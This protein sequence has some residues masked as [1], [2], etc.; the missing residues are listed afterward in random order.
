MDL[1][2]VRHGQSVGNRDRMVQSADTPL[3]PAGFEQAA[4]TGRWLA[5]YFARRGT[6]PAALYSS[7][8]LRAW[9]TAEI[10]GQDLRL[11]PIAEPRLRE[12]APGD[13][14]GLSYDDCL[15]RFPAAAAARADWSNMDWGWPG[16]ETRGQVE[17]R[18]LAAIA[19][20]AA[21]HHPGDQVVAVTHGGPIWAY[22]RTL[23]SAQATLAA[24]NTGPAAAQIRPGLADTALEVAIC[25]ITHIH[26]PTEG[27]TFGVGCLLALGQADHLFGDGG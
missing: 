6:P 20:L 25:S 1:Y 13:A 8:F 10:I 23:E 18:V 27:E 17:A 15:A 3:A 7:D 22:L 26:F 19:D 9:Q 2:L 4:I 5:R 14:A 11:T 21:R 16:G 12:R 24:A